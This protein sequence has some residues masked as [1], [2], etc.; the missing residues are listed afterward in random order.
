M[1][2]FDDRLPAEMDPQNEELIDLLRQ[3][4]GVPAGAEPE[5]EQ[6]ALALA[7]VRQRL[8]ATLAASSPNSALRLVEIDEAPEAP[9]LL[10]QKSAV[11]VGRHGWPRRFALIAASLV[12]ALLVGS[13]LAIFRLATLGPS[14][15]TRGPSAIY[16]WSGGWIRMFN[17][18][19]GALLWKDQVSVPGPL[20]GGAI[21]LG[22]RA[23]VPASNGII[24]VIVQQQ[25]LALKASDGRV[26]WSEDID[27][28]PGA[29]TVVEDSTVYLLLW[30][31]GTKG[32]L[33]A[34]DALSGRRLWHY[35]GPLIGGRFAVVNQVVYG[36]LS[37]SDNRAN[38][39][40]FALDAANGS[41]QWRVHIDDPSLVSTSGSITVADGK[42]YFPAN[43]KVGTQ[44]FSRVYA[45]TSEHGGFLWRS[46]DLPDVS[47]VTLASQKTI[48]VAYNGLYALNAQNGKLLW[49]DPEV[50]IGSV[51]LTDGEIFGMEADKS[52]DYIVEVNAHNGKVIARHLM[53]GTGGADAGS[54]AQV[55]YVMSAFISER[56]SYMVLD[57]GST[58]SAFDNQTGARLW[59]AKLI[60]G[61]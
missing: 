4:H 26:L 58:L 45:Y 49:G 42:V 50:G 59:S 14:A 22:T 7:R 52:G 39:D 57:R 43:V 12:V 46:P 16:V 60:T 34:F 29:P 25:L 2:S 24:Y 41:Q 21:P 3:V 6:Q 32:S 35:D 18:Q 28:V 15:A 37:L 40:L 44:G 11:P 13:M 48:Y 51:A 20:P 56:T 17:A 53:E 33:E 23:D 9:S 27:G 36:G 1:Q 55:L 47:D 19:D 8:L 61:R 38:F 54:F 30:K 10:A 31:D 5:P